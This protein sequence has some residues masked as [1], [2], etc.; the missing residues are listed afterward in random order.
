MVEGKVSRRRLFALLAGGPPLILVSGATIRALRSQLRKR[1]ALPSFSKKPGGIVIHH[2]AARPSR[3]PFENA[4]TIEEDHRRR[5]FGAWYKGKVYHIAYH[6]VILP[7]GTIEKGRPE[8]CRGGHTRS[9][10]HNRWVGICLVGYFDS[11]WKNRKYHRPTRAQMKSLVSLSVRIMDSYRLDQTRILPHKKINPTQCP[12]K[13]FPMN[14]YISQVK[15]ELKKS[16]N[17]T[18]LFSGLKRG[19][20]WTRKG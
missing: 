18:G 6:Y 17:T 3:Q 11:G 2:S 9:W 20:D 16:K 1:H 15:A 14:E 8:K 5:G 7:D 19:T 4:K 12:G 10:K 13:S